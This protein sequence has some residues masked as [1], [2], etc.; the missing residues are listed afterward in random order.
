MQL[1]QPDYI[2]FIICYYKSIEYNIY[3]FID[4]IKIRGLTR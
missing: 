1:H 4:I 3:N 2:I